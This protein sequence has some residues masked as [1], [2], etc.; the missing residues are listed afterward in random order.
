MSALVA[1]FSESKVKVVA[2][3]THPI[4]I[5]PRVRSFDLTHDLLYLV[6]VPQHMVP[7]DNAGLSI[8]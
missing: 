6:F 3:E 2:S 5:P 4:S 8:Q 1:V 7:V